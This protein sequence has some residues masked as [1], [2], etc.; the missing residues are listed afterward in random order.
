ME[1]TCLNDCDQFNIRS[2]IMQPI[3]CTSGVS[4]NKGPEMAEA[5]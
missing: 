2:Y 4:L 3:S 5:L 1:Y